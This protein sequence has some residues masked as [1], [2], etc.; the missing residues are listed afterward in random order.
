MDIPAAA[1]CAV[2]QR[3][4][5]FRIMDHPLVHAAAREFSSGFEEGTLQFFDAALP[6]CTRMI[7]FGGYF[8]FTALYAATSVPEVYAFEPSPTNF[9]FMTENVA[10][11]PELATRIRLFCH[12]V[13]DRDDKVVLYAK[14]I[15]DYTGLTKP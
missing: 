8:G 6:D 11:N 13:A 1:G 15:G 3:G 5:T 9:A 4:R 12:G 14:A 10:C 2:E 7:D